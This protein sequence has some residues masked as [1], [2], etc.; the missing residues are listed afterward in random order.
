MKK[1]LYIV[2]TL[3]RTGP[4]NVLFNLVS[5]L[6]RNQFYPIILT[7]S[8]E[9]STF[10]SLKSEFEKLNVEIHT[11]GLSR[12]SGFLFGNIK[13]A[14]FVKKEKIDVIHIN[15]FRGDWMIRHSDFSKTKLVTTINSNIYDDYTMLYGKIKGRIMAY[16][17]MH[18]IK[19]KTAIGCSEFV[20]KE[21]N[22]RYSANLKVIYNG[23]PKEKYVISP[24]AAK[25]KIRN[26]LGLPIHKKV[27]IFV[28]YLIYR[29]DPITVIEGFIDSKTEVDNDSILL[30]LGDG[31]LMSAC[32]TAADDRADIKFLGNQPETL[33]YLQASDFYIASAFSEGL[34]TSVMEAM[35]CG[36]PVI[37]SEIAP[38]NEIISKIPRWNYTFPIT[39]YKS[40]G[41]KMTK[42]LQDDYD[43]ISRQCR[44]VIEEQINANLMAEGYQTIYQAQ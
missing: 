21:L 34:P 30:M 11:I 42:A 15:G 4:T 14:E 13:I 29:K 7:L 1:I 39:D 27:F 3:Q 43:N 38:H 20:A 19:G 22:S 33:K 9:N 12:V 31:P 26:E 28:G 44:D 24:P 41:E 5:K 18:S 6:D 16:L 36:L 35:G 25:E 17:H 10:Y 37:L 23:I 2:S 40:L 32:K 8:P